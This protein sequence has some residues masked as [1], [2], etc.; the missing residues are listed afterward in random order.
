MLEE[1]QSGLYQR[2]KENRDA[3]FNT[4]HDKIYHMDVLK[5]AWKIVS[6]NNGTAG[7]D[8]QTISD[9]E[10]GGYEQ[11]L[12]EIQGELKAGTY[13]AECVKRVFIPKPNGKMRPLG[14]PTVKDRIVQ[15]AVKLIMEPIYEADFKDF[16]YAYRKNKSAKDASL[17]IYKWL[18]FGLTDVIDVDIEGFF[19]HLD[20]E[21]LI[22]FV[23][24]RVTDG[25]VI[26]L[27]KQWLKAGVVYM[28]TRT[29][30]TEGTP[31][32]GVISPL[33]ANIYLN[34]LDQAWTEM[35]M[36]DNAGQNAHMIRYSDDLVI[37][38]KSPRHAFF[39]GKEHARN[40]MNALKS[41]LKKLKLNLSAEKSRVTTAEEGFDFLGFHFI[42]R[43]NKH[44]EK[45][46]TFFFPS[47]KSKSSFMKKAS[48]ITHRRHAHTKSE[49]DVIKELNFLIRGW[50]NYFN[51]SHAT[52]VYSG[53]WTF[54]CFRLTQFMRYRHKLNHLGI[55]YDKIRSYGLLPLYGRIKHPYSVCPR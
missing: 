41:I 16:S 12:K 26:S 55:D 5:E 33:L 3:K 42:R 24:K 45:E 52:R 9:I 1:L 43:Q 39:K 13:K 18:N 10:A 15:Q 4:L 20:H 46:V 23:K 17:E 54:V 44:R 31:Q 32:G 29:N 36:D 30:P 51:H 2:A 7:I 53:L 11:F 22:S 14:I 37:L 21:L 28:N 19:D 8:N 25:Y 48:E 50:T 6:E 27:I 49:A 38:T 47:K 35:G 40:I 34:E